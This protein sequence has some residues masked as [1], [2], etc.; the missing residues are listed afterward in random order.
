M[1]KFCEFFFVYLLSSATSH[2]WINVHIYFEP[3][4]YESEY[5]NILAELHIGYLSV[6]YLIILFVF[7]NYPRR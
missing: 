7:V 4:S 2:I 1:N 3:K 6:K 5:T